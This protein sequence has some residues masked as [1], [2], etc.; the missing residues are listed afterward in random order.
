[1]TVA[2]VKERESFV[3][4]GEPNMEK[5][6]T[7]C[8]KENSPLKDGFDHIIEEGGLGDDAEQINTEMVSELV[9]I[10]SLE[11]QLSEAHLARQQQTQEIAKLKAGIA[12]A[13]K[14]D[15]NKQ[16]GGQINVRSDCFDYDEETD[17]VKVVKEEILQQELEAH[18]IADQDR[19][20]KLVQMR[21][22]VLSQV[23]GI[24]RKRRGRVSSVCS[25]TSVNSGVGR[26]RW[27][28]SGDESDEKE[29]S[30]KAAR[31]SQ[32]QSLL[33]KPKTK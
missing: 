16:K 12:Q 15:I 25:V 28:S 1:M 9:K 33:P 26:V 23:K 11:K 14:V 10:N 21:N 18:C 2:L 30:N 20:K 6:Q 8:L 5:L 27:R 7:P 3:K 24:E 32:S 29:S 31:L 4:K 17:T 13:V 22:R 19:E